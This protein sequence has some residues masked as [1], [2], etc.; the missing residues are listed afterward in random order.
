MTKQ[1]LE[2]IKDYLN[3]LVKFDFD[4]YITDHF[5]NTELGNVMQLSLKNYIRVLLN[6][7]K[8]L[9]IQILR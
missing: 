7:S 3:E 8:L 2:T 4:K 5:P 9:Y 6:V 1:E